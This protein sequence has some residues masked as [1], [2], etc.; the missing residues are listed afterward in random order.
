[1][2]KRIVIFSQRLELYYFLAQRYAS[3][4][5]VERRETWYEWSNR[6]IENI[7]E[8]TALVIFDLEGDFRVAVEYTRKIRLDGFA[9]KLLFLFCAE[10]AQQKIAEK[11]RAIDAG[12]DEYLGYPQTI[13]EIA[14]SV[15]ALLR[16]Y[17]RKEELEFLIGGER[18]FVNPKARKVM[19][20]QKELAFTKTEFAI[21]QYLLFCLNRNVSHKELYEAVWKKEY[22]HDDMNIMAHVHRMRKKMGDDRKDP[23]YIQNIYGIG[24]MIEGVQ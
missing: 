20:N 19:M 16:H 23:R 13:E 18:F 15:K 7:R 4:F 1:M 24:Y 14:A 2:Q 22:M 12:A 17:G 8:D 21:F 11:I 6:L 3:A 10:K 9:G 5:E